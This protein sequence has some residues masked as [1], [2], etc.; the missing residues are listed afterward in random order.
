VDAE[1]PTLVVL[2]RPWLRGWSLVGEGGTSPELFPV[3][4]FHLGFVA[5][6]GEQSYELRFAPP[7]LCGAQLASLLAWLLLLGSLLV[8][9]LR[10]WSR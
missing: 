8:G 10:G 3:D 5:P 7:G 1:G 6:A 9:R 2:L 4:A